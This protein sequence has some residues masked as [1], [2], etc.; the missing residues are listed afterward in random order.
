MTILDLAVIK[1]LFQERTPT[2]I[3]NNLIDTLEE[4][5]VSM[6][7]IYRTLKKMERLGYINSSWCCGTKKYKSTP[8]GQNLVNKIMQL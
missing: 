7:N 3:T 2:E 5:T 6:P 1:L 8:K 4:C